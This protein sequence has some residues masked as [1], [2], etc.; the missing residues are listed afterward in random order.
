M[1]PSIKM[2]PEVVWFSIQMEK[3]LRDHDHKGGWDECENRWLFTRLE[4]EIGELHEAL[5]VGWLER[6]EGYGKA[7]TINRK[8]AI[9]EC[10]DIANFA[11]MIAD[12]IQHKRGDQS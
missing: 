2:R 4:E 1:S 10:V 8:R 12:N 9:K 7:L 5:N 6:I 3:V 11:M